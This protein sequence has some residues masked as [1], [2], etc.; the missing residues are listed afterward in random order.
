MAQIFPVVPIKFQ[1]AKLTALPLEDKKNIVRAAAQRTDFSKAGFRR[2][3]F[4]AQYA[5]DLCNAAMSDNIVKK[6]F[7]RR[8]LAATRKGIL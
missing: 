5:A 8:Y 4:W 1:R 7:R 3:C 2:A 6:V